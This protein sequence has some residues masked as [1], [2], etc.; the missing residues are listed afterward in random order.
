VARALAEEGAA[1]LADR[2]RAPTTHL[3]AVPSELFEA[4]LAVRRAHPTWGPAKVRAFLGRRAPER[5]RP[6]RSTIG[7]LF[8]R[9][10]LTVKRRAPPGGPLFA[11]AAA[12]DVWTI[13]FKGWFRTGDGIR[14]DPLTLADA[15]SRYLLRCQAV[16]HPDGE[17]LWPI[18]DAAFREYGLPLRLRSDVEPEV[19]LR[20][21]GPP[22][23]TVGAGGL[24]RMAVKVIK[25]GVTPERIRPGKP[26]GKRPAGAAAPD[27]APRR[28]QPAGGQPAR[29]AGPLPG[30][31]EE[32]QRGVAP[33]RPRRRHPRPTGA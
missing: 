9:E 19:R 13:D 14:V 33:C 7:A 21:N 23:A 8:D 12:N 31:P 20:R 22:F 17:H 18:L 5:P 4:C 30:L 29:P 15:C 10:G 24:S 6:A 16:A 2:S 25:A 1:G 11:A 26:P 28:R 3:H 32:L 27:A